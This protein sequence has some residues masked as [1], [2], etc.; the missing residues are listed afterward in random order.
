MIWI[1]FRSQGIRLLPISASLSASGYEFY[2]VVVV[3]RGECRKL[4]EFRSLFQSVVD[5]KVGQAPKYPGL[6]RKLVTRLGFNCWEE[7][8]PVDVCNHVNLLEDDDPE[9]LSQSRLFQLLQN[10]FKYGSFK[11]ESDN[12]M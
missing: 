6:G 4:T 12:F 7:G 8:R 10:D 1:R 5:A 3:L 2:T 9:G 11:G